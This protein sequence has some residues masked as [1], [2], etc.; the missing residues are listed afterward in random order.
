MSFEIAKANLSFGKA[1]LDAIGNDVILWQKQSDCLEYL[2][3]LNEQNV[4]LTSQIFNRLNN[5]AFAYGEIPTPEQLQEIF[6]DTDEDERGILSFAQFT[7]NALNKYQEYE[8]GRNFYDRL[9]EDNNTV[10]AKITVKINDNVFVKYSRKPL[11]ILDLYWAGKF[12]KAEYLPAHSQISGRLIR[13]SSFPALGGFIQIRPHLF[14]N[15]LNI[16]GLVDTES[17]EHNIELE[18]IESPKN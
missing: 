18:L 17:G 2:R 10:K 14:G 16:A 3:D 6:L 9:T 1:Y 8:T 4:D 13:I 7:R 12:Q 5:R 11:D 15:Y